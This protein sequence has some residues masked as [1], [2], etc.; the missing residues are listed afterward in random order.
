VV[1]VVVVA[2]VPAAAAVAMVCWV[3]GASVS[4]E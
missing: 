2:L 3:E 4:D 1:V